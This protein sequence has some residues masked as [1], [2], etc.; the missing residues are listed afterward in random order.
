V[1]IPILHNEERV[2]TF[3]ISLDDFTDQ[4]RE[5]LGMLADQAG[6]ALRSMQEVEQQEKMS[7][8]ILLALTRSVDAKS[9]WTGGHSERVADLS[10]AIGKELGMNTEEIQNLRVSALLH[11]IGKLGIPE[12]ILDK[13]EK[14]TDDEFDLV[15]S[16]PLKGDKIIQDIPGFEDVRL[17]VRHHHEKWNGLGY[18][19]GLA[20]KEIPRIARILTLADVYDAI[21]EDRPYR[22]GFT[23][24]ESLQFL[25]D[26]SGLIFDP[27]LLPA[28]LSLI[29][30]DRL[31]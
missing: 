5:A 27:A 12:V 31:S 22:K 3:M 4:D 16:H 15:K 25:E 7:R 24:E 23:R 20:G 14:L 30:E 28:F 21:T 6:V 2:A 10:E 13:P 1:A 26:Q 11:D 29:L 19:D 18:P 17:G 9:R 8:G